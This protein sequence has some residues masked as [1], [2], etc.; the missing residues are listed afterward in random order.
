MEERDYNYAEAFRKLITAKRSHRTIEDIVA[1]LQQKLSPVN[2][3]SLLVHAMRLLIELDKKASSPLYQHLQSPMRQTLYMIDVYYSIENR[4]ET[5]EMDEPG[6]ER[7]AR[8]LDEIEMAYF[9][10]IAFPNNGDIF[11][12][13]RDEQIDV[14]LGT[15]IGYYGNAVLSF[16]EQILDR[17]ER[18]FLPYDNSVQA[19]F[20]FTVAEAIQ[21]VLH[22]RKL[23]ND[24]LNHL[25]RPFADTFS[26]YSNNPDEW[27][28]L[29]DRFIARGVSDPRD[30]W[31]QPELSGLTNTYR[32]NP[33]EINIHSREELMNVA[34]DANSLQHVLSFLSYDK[35]E[36]KGKT[37]YYAD[38]RHSESHPLIQ[39]GDQYVCPISK[40]LIE[41]LYYR[42]DEALQKDGKLGPKY[43][44]NKDAA[45]EKKVVDIFQHF[46][47]QKTKIFAN[48]SVDGVSENDLLVVFGDTCIVVEM[49]NCG[50]RPPFRDPMKAYERIKTDYGKAIQLG[51]EQC[52]R[53]EDILLSGKDVE[54]R[55]GE[56]MSKVLYTLKHRN[57]GQV[58]SMVVTDFKYGMIQ[59]DLSKMLVK[60]DDDL[61]PWSVCVDDLE[62]LFM[63][64]RKLL[65]GIAPDRFVEFLDFRERFQGHMV[66]YD[67]LEICGWYLCDREQFKKYANSESLVNT[68]PNM[69]VIFDA[70][71]HT[72]LGFKNE[73]DMDYKRHNRLEEYPKEFEMNEYTSDSFKE[74]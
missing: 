39:M 3:K 46:F 47:P 50:F 64:M 52:K 49:K 5:D 36:Q 23:N 16:E 68:S 19:K 51:Y 38:K 41:G 42:I 48:Y 10:N 28:K 35:D 61:Y 60:E 17:I 31:D 56:K 20:G 15:F 6:W 44:K 25:M 7:V 67:E 32:T 40:F 9:V 26:F 11:H 54:I 57:I 18:Y 4:E 55:D 63:M 13:E 69:G 66:C 73:L 21:F 1:N 65:K 33:G 74:E 70:Y 22:V 37:I 62:T 30:W 27:K 43:K 14:A 59:T 29:T 72:G 34:M 24:K 2:E 53:V 71:Y 58:W 12:D 8:L 45:F